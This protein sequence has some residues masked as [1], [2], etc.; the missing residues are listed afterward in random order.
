MRIE[1]NRNLHGYSIE[2]FK[3]YK[4]FNNKNRRQNII[5]K[6]EANLA[7]FHILNSRA[8]LYK[9]LRLLK[10][11]QS[12]FAVVYKKYMRLFI[13][14]TKNNVEYND[15]LEVRNSI[16]FYNSFLSDIYSINDGKYLFDDVK[17]K[18]EWND[19]ELLFESKLHLEKFQKGEFFK[20]DFSYNTILAKHCSKFDSQ[21]E[22]VFD[23]FRKDEELTVLLNLVKQ[24]KDENEEF[25]LV[26]NR[27]FIRSDFVKDAAEQTKI[28]YDILKSFTIPKS[29][30]KYEIPIFYKQ[31]ESSIL[32]LKTKI[33][34]DVIKKTLFNYLKTQISCKEEKRNLPFLPVF[35]DIAYDFI[36]FPVD[37]QVICG[38]EKL[39][40]NKNN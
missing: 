38:L 13:E 34:N 14:S 7:K 32:N 25:K 11:D 8:Y 10:N 40:L 37:D 30:V 28:L 24:F 26:L 9:N 2:Q 29:S 20:N 22:R 16:C 35:Y 15:I 36:D 23:G 31:I 17:I 3:A 21:K 12:E 33:P 1:E 18:Y 5:F 19:V 4:K 27:N 39:E 6:L